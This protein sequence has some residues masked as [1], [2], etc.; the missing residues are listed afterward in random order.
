LPVALPEGVAGPGDFDTI[1]VTVEAAS[2]FVVNDRATTRENVRDYVRALHGEN[3]D[4]KFV[5]VLG[6]GSRLKD[7]ALAV[8]AGRSIG[9]H[10]V[11]V[12]EKER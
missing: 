9:H 3:P 1:H 10:V 6:P 4:A 8:E 5:V 12:M 7:T 11:T 2:R